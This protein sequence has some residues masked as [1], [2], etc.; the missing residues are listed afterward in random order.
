MADGRGIFDYIEVHN[1]TSLTPA[2]DF[3]ES[4]ECN[5]ADINGLI[6]EIANGNNNPDF[7][8]TGEGTVDI[9]DRD[10]W[11]SEAASENG[12]TTP[13]QAGDTNLDRIV[14]ISDLNSLA[15]AWNTAGT[16]WSQGNFNGDARTDIVDLNVIAGN[17]GM[18]AAAVPDAAVPEP[19]PVC[20]IV[21]TGI[22]LLARRRR[23]NGGK[24]GTHF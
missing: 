11:L 14:D 5:V 1:Q 3:D 10:V 12:F 18:E 23:S 8:I 6:D 7:D 20:M 24:K 21:L 13:Y 2:C 22:S 16:N 9:T 19:S 4:S 17:W 15:L